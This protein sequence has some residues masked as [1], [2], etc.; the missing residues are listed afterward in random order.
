MPVLIWVQGQVILFRYVFNTPFLQC[1]HLESSQKCNQDNFHHHHGNM[2]E[3]GA[4]CLVTSGP[5]SSTHIRLPG[6]HRNSRMLDLV[7][8]TR[9]LTQFPP[10][11]NEGC[12]ERLCIY[13]AQ[14]KLGTFPL[15]MHSHS[16]GEQT[17]YFKARTWV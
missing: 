4:G 10:L 7:E 16:K 1:L 13:S 15:F 9:M 2:G 6:R 11:N 3:V 12:V 8:K 17:L 5:L 14:G